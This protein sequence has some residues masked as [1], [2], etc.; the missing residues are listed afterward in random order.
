MIDKPTN[1]LIKHTKNFV[2]EITV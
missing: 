1:K 2:G